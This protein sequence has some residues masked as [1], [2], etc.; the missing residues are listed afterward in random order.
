L[1]WRL[2]IEIATRAANA[3]TPN[4]AEGSGTGLGLLSSGGRNSIP[5]LGAAAMSLGMSGGN[6]GLTLPLLEAVGFLFQPV[7]LLRGV[8]PP[9]Q[10][11]F[12]PQA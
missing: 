7:N 3:N 4:E 9:K 12:C 6:G 11:L 5:Y 1:C 8:S 2:R 10:R